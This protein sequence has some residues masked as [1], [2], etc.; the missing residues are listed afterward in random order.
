MSNP[1]VIIEPTLSL[2]LTNKV[3]FEPLQHHKSEIRLITLL[4]GGLEDPLIASLSSVSLLDFPPYEALSYVWG[5]EK[6]K[7]SL[8]V[9]GIDF[10]VH[11]NLDSALRHMRLLD[12]SRVL[13][14]DAICIDQNNL[15]ERARQVALMGKVYKQANRTLIWLGDSDDDSRTALSFL[16]NLA[17]GG[18]VLS[19]NGCAGRRVNSGPCTSQLAALVRLFHRP[20]WYRIWVIQESTTSWDRMVC[21]G[22]TQIGWLIWK[23]A[24]VQ[25][26]NQL[27]VQS[28]CSS[29]KLCSYCLVGTRLITSKVMSMVATWQASC[30]LLELVTHQRAQE[31]TDP[32]DKIYGLL[33]LATDDQVRVTTID[34]SF[35][36][37]KVYQQFVFNDILLQKSL[38]SLGAVSDNKET[39]LVLPSWVPDW[40]SPPTFMGIPLMWLDRYNKYN[41]C[42]GLPVKG[43]LTSSDGVLSI[44]GVYVDRVARIGSLTPQYDEDCFQRAMAV[45]QW[46]QMAEDGQDFCRPY[47]GGGSVKNAFWRTV[48]ADVKCKGSGVEIS[49]AN[50]TY[51]RVGIEDEENFWAAWVLE[52]GDSEGITEEYFEAICS[53]GMIDMARMGQWINKSQRM[54]SNM[55]LT[56]SG[57]SFFITEKGYMGNGP[58]K[59]MVGDEVHVLRGGKLP[60]VLH[61]DPNTMVDVNLQEE[62]GSTIY[63]LCGQCYLHGI[64]DGEA[65]GN[66]DKR[67]ARVNIR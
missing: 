47:V 14:A 43:A 23:Q 3:L 20:W 65:A 34:Y 44:P 25:L 28:C 18:H 21:C 58:W 63:T 7:K 2:S 22:E 8:R 38:R 48:I 37:E 13:W 52:L 15:A 60:L 35:S 10:R 24:V 56:S 11:E 40:T 27:H 46:K 61:R 42:N 49:A 6:D 54:L 57:Q 31:A 36:I 19:D 12:K 67:A 5:A 29:V 17:D 33:G 53:Q 30:D 16:K 1:E 62:F 55:I 59:M 66:F 32:R 64:M 41:A 4:P 39:K 50:R 26:N 45:R 9:N 51:D